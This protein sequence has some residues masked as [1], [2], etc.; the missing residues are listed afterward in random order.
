MTA[1]TAAVGRPRTDVRGRLIYRLR[2]L[3]REPVG[4]A[5]GGLGLLLVY[6]VI[7]P[8]V[9]MLSDALVV[10]PADSL[11]VGQPAGAVTTY[12]VDRTLTSAISPLLFWDPLTHT[13]VVAVGTTALALGLGASLAWLVVRTDMPLRRWLAGALVVPYMMPSWT[14]ALAW[15]TLF[16]NRTIAGQQGWLESFGFDPP[17]WLAYG[18]V[19][20]E[21]GRAHV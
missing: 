11:R 2:A 15:V 10:A 14:F 3:R 5:G 16:K 12:Y 7:A 20:I 13:V 9:S 4:L 17:D 21:I 19:P 6:L 1:V 18:G 8:I